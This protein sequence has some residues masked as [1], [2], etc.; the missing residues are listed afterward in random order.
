MT[1]SG[2]DSSHVE[3]S[4]VHDEITNFFDDITLVNRG[5]FGSIY[6]AYANDTG[7]RTIRPPPLQNGRWFALKKVEFD[8]EL[9][10]T[11]LI[12]EIENIKQSKLRSGVTYYGCFID[13]QTGRAWVV[14]SFIEGLNL[15][16]VVRTVK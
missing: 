12:D 15:L 14:M 6:R 11:R 13:D 8:S 7:M 1:T 16:E 2:T 5:G 3:E 10:K 4:F 9:T